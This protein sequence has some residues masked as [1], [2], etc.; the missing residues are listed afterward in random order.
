VG[1]YNVVAPCVVGKLHYTRPTVQ[2][3]EV[4]DEIAGPLVESGCLEP[5]PAGR[6]ANHTEP[7]AD[8]P[9]DSLAPGA[10]AAA[11]RGVEMANEFISAA[12]RKFAG[13]AEELAQEERKLKEAREAV[14]ESPSDRAPRQSRS[15]SRRKPAE[16]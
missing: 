2:P 6:Q 11:E 7:T 4:D 9:L 16:D 1:Y 12:G 10:G 13:A 14:E 8:D 15:R 3:I 5:Y